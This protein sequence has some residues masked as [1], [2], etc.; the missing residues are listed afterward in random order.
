M[1]Q[2]RLADPE[3]MTGRTTGP[4]T[5]GSPHQEYQQDAWQQGHPPGGLR[6]LLLGK[7]GAGKSAT[8]NTIL[9]KD[10][11]T[12]KFSEQRVTTV[13]KKEEGSVT[14]EK[15]V[16][17][18]TPDL[19]SSTICAK[20]KQR[21][22][23][24][25]LAL[26][27]PSLHA[28]LL[29][30]PIGHYQMEDREAIRGIQKVFGAGAVRHTIIIF[31]RKDE[32][33]D[34]SIQDYFE[35]DSSVNEL[36]E[37]CRSQY[38]AFNNKAEGA[39]RHS[40]VTELLGRVKRLVDENGGPYSVDIRNEGSGFQDCVK[41]AASQKED[42][43]HN[44]P[45]RDK[46]TAHPDGTL[47]DTNS[48]TLRPAGDSGICSARPG[49][50]QLWASGSEP[51]P[52]T[53]ELKVLLVGRRGVGKSTAGN[54]LL[55]KRAFQ[56]KF[57]DRWVT[58]VFKSESRVWKGRE[59]LIIDSPDLSRDFTPA[60]QE[61]APQGPHAFLLVIP[62]GS[63]SEND[64]AV[65]TTLRRRFGD[66]FREHTV[67]LLTRKED[68]R[69]E[70]ADPLSETTGTIKELIEE[71]GHRYSTFSYSVSADEERRQ[72]GALLDKVV[73]LVQRNG[74]K[75]CGFAEE[76]LTI[77]LVGRS[78]TGKSATGNTILGRSEFVSQL[79]AQPVTKEV[80]DS[81][82][83]VDEQDIMVV[84]TPALHLMLSEE[85]N[86]SQLKKF[87]NYV[88]NCD[89]NTVLVLVLQ[90]GRFTQQDE[91]EVA[92]LESI[93]G[94]D[95]TKSMIVLFTRKEDLGGGDLKD[96]CNNTDNKA[97]R[98]I[99]KKCKGRVCAFN[100]KETGQDS[101]D[102]VTDLLKKA[103]EL[104]GNRDGHGYF[105]TQETASKR[106]KNA[107]EKQ[108]STKKENIQRWL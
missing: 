79:R 80:Q 92:M 107:Q 15:V 39:E 85:G 50:Q 29:V 63:F 66:K 24:Y 102:Q 7:R 1:A 91:E 32:L 41:E 3:T 35:S 82:G 26:S 40:Q 87:Q 69:D 27:A 4:R 75:P 88:S 5:S 100:N 70:E 103:K 97:L 68:R 44:L 55:G 56:T 22:I 51:N 57:S 9:G 59:I 18:D 28:L 104:I 62:L 8:G 53:S 99:I 96:Y 81:R 49:E 45:R 16:V 71:G 98:K 13:C 54:R 101:K 30:V 78:G 65:L 12:S 108:N 21:H 90:L 106:A 61:H 19:Y 10:V 89:G 2:V 20:D 73:H 86:T 17:I 33:G 14:G 25:C 83:T 95:V 34:D 37:T 93:V 43:P 46:V 72:V 58:R 23:E 6:L 77:V 11:F 64:E 105:C 47:D 60:L 31:T 67:V 76:I 74:D 84:D 36:V 48:V 52:G 94:K 42:N 38:C